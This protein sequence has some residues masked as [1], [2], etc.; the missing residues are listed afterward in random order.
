MKFAVWVLGALVLLLLV[1]VLPASG[2]RLDGVFR[3]PV[4]VALLGIV[5]CANVVAIT[6]M[7]RQ[8]MRNRLLALKQVGFFLSHLSVVLILSGGFL[9]YLYGLEGMFLVPVTADVAI[10][11]SYDGGLELDFELTADDLQIEYYEPTHYDLFVLSP[12]DD[13]QNASH[14][15][16][17]KV[18]IP[19]AGKVMLDDANAIDL[20]DLKHESGG[21]KTFYQM[22][23]G[24]VLQISRTVKHYA[25]QVSFLS[26][27]G[28]VVKSEIAVNHPLSFDGWRFYLMSAK[29]GQPYIVLSG[30]RDPGWP[31][32]HTGIWMMMVGVAI[33]CFRK[34]GRE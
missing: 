32:V 23:D 13:P 27:N 2:T 14:A 18:R 33:T 15:F 29:E 21:W 28:D 6:A 31:L 4:F 12:G 9:R 20:A 17:R 34:A 30:K 25:A 16:S 5:A 8:C 24:S 26:Q 10:S 11:D 3:S 7:L 1:G 19:D 22:D